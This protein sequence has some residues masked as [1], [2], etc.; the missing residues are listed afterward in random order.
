[1]NKPVRAVVRYRSGYLMVATDGGI[2]NFSRAPF[3]GSLG[4][5]AIRQPIINAAAAG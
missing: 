3:F 4:G 5:T 2:F 1:M